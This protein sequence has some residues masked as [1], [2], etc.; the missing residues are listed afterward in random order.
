M[1]E[2]EI[3]D[4]NIFMMCETL[5]VNALTELPVGYSIRNCKPDELDIWKAMPFDSQDLARAY[6]EYM[7]DYFNMVYG[8]K[9]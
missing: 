9:K 8:D 4:K 1:T 3:P 5:N 7:T 2:E 6:D